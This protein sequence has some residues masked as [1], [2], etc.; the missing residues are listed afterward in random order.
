MKNGKIFL[1]LLIIVT[2]LFGSPQFSASQIRKSAGIENNKRTGGYKQP[3]GKKIRKTAV[4]SENINFPTEKSSKPDTVYCTRTKKQHGWFMP[5]DTISK[6]YASHRNLSFRFTHKYPSGYWG[7]M[8]TI[9]GY[10]RPTTSGLSPY[11]LNVGSAA[12]DGKARQDWVEKVKEGCIY[13]FVADPSGKVVVQERAYDKDMNLIYAYSRVPIGKGVFVGSYKD[14]YGLPAEM[15]KDSACSYGTLVRLTEDQWGN[16]SIVE[17][18]DSKGKTK[19]NSD[20]V[21]MEVYVCDKH[22]HVLKQQSRDLEGKLVRD[23]WG[24]C[25]IEYVWNDKHQLLCATHM[26]EHW[27]PMKMPDKRLDD[28]G[29]KVGTERTCFKY[30]AY[31]RLTDECFFTGDGVVD[32]NDYGIHHI[33]YDF[34]D[35]GNIEGIAKYDA[36]ES[37]VNDSTGTARYILQYDSEGRQLRA[38][39]YDC[40]MKPAAKDNYLSKRIKE[41]DE[42]GNLLV[43]RA[44]FVSNG[45]ER[46][47]YEGVRNKKIISERGKTGSRIDSLDDKGRTLSTTYRDSSG[48]LSDNDNKYAIARYTYEDSPGRAVSTASYFDK[49]GDLCNSL[50]GRCAV[51]RM[52]VDTLSGG[53]YRRFN[54]KYDAGGNL[55]ETYLQDYDNDGNLAGQNDVNAFGVICRAGGSGPR[56]YRGDVQTTPNGNYSTIIGRDE[57]GEPDY[58]SSPSELYYYTT[59]NPAGKNIRWDENGNIIEDYEKFK[60]ECPKLM[61]VEV[62]DSMAYGLGIRDNDVILMDG[63]YT[64]DIFARDSQTLLDFRNNWALHCVLDGN[65]ERSMLVFRVDPATMEYGLVKIGG[66]RGTPSELGYLV[67]VRY[68]TRKQLHRIQE[69][70]MENIESESPLAKRSDFHDIDYSGDHRVVVAYADHYRNVRN[71]PY[72]KHISDPCV[73]LGS[74]IPERKIKWSVDDGNSIDGFEQMLSSRKATRYKFPRQEF[75]FTKD[76]AAISRLSTEEQYIGMYFYSMGISDECYDRLKGL[77]LAA[78]DSVSSCLKTKESYPAKCFYGCWKT[79][80]KTSESDFSPEV[81]LCLMKNG[82]MRGIMSFFCS[83]E[84]DGVTVVFRLDKAIEGTWQNGGKWLFNDVRSSCDKL[85]CIDLLGCENEE[86]KAM[87]LSRLNGL[88]SSDAS[89]YVKDFPFNCE[90]IENGFFISRFSKQTMEAV[91]SPSDTVTLVK[92][93]EI[94]EFKLHDGSKP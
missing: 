44:C 22:G 4:R 8:E 67:H 29:D 72:A 20:G 26:D 89:A 17:Y 94:P 64:S 37:L 57:F 48:R 41:Y 2:A 47:A 62:V 25:G 53:R 3:A 70:V 19:P 40:N 28:V 79:K 35:K 85:S 92:T 77:L 55:V 30:D 90:K 16:D 6:E 5:M 87:E 93:K 54:K 50:D 60:D 42:K 23:N 38:E 10:G 86:R 71:M 84:K 61:S 49:N 51:W 73:L 65:K 13:E 11:I 39:F 33:H 56:H 27:K 91:V 69:T 66:L 21:A 78:K 9:D 63:N 31:G 76:G 75:Y 34:D 1:S 58:I 18:T 83:Y 15:R 45:V 74:C 82:E 14:S 80:D 43:E 7:K 36:T 68:L 59:L 88:F 81:H 32:T 12:S 46:V 24:N 52:V